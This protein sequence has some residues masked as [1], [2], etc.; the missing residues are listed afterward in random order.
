MPAEYHILNGDCLK[1]QLDQT[2][3]QGELIVCRES[4]I[5]GAVDAFPIEKFWDQRAEF[6]SKAFNATKEEY[7]QKSVTEFKK[8]DVIPDGSEINLWFENDLFCQ[9]NMWFVLSLLAEKASK[10]K[11]YRIFPEITSASDYWTGFGKATTEDLQKAYIN[12]VLFSEADIRLG[13]TLWNGYRNND[14]ETL[15]LL[16]HAKSECYENL[17]EVC[18][19]NVERFPSE[20]NIVGRPERVLKEIMEKEGTDFQTILTEFCKTK[21]I[22]GLGD[23]QVKRIYEK[24]KRNPS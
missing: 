7:Y 18:K 1:W 10:Y 22:Y 5:E 11:I 16:S 9:V 6:V 13:N 17:V 14:L 15:L 24:I 20:S 19:A 12:R 3:I 21:G 23:L 4:L 2:N 8:L